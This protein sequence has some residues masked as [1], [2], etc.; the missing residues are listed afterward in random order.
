MPVIHL[1]SKDLQIIESALRELRDRAQ[2][3]NF[4]TPHV[5]TV[6]STLTKVVEARQRDIGELT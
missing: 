6:N 5:H 4:G 2:A 3:S 1:T